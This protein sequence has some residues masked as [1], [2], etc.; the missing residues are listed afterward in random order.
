MQIIRGYKAIPE[1]L[2]PVVMTIGTYDGLHLGHRAIIN[3]VVTHARREGLPALVYSFY[4]P[5]WRL[6][7]RGSFPFLILTLEDKIAL[8]EE[9]GVDVLVTEEFTEELRS[10]SP[11]EFAGGVLRDRLQPKEI[12]VGYDFRFGRGRAGDWR[13]LESHLGPHGTDVRPH[14]AVRVDGEIIGCS[15]IREHICE[16]RVEVAGNLLGRHHGVR[17][18]VQHGDKRGRT[19]GFPTAN[20][21]PETELV[22]KAG[23][24]AVWMQRSHGDRLRGIANVGV[25]PT[26]GGDPK[27]RVEVHLFDFDGDLY[28]EEVVVSFVFRVRDER[29]FDGIESLVQQIKDDVRAVREQDSWPEPSVEDARIS[30]DPKPV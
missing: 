8:L 2:G 5:P 18:V 23:V 13:F 6:L 12:H 9:M 10:Q 27:T 3:R 17:G 28:G 29:A 4:P 15:G 11:V 24:Y 30:W 25:R 21:D 22:P 14:G 16:G 7:G 19:I 26:F 20:V 1:G